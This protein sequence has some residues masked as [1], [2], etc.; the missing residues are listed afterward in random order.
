MTKTQAKDIAL[1]HLDEVNTL[2]FGAVEFLLTEPREFQ[3]FWY[4][5]YKVAG[6]IMLA[7]AP[8]FRI[9]KKTGDIDIVDWTEYQNFN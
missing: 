7:G 5:D 1:K 6:D 4:F 8:G 2:Q 9:D 3:G